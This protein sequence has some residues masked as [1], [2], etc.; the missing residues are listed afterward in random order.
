[1]SILLFPLGLLILEN[2]PLTYIYITKHM[3]NTLQTF[4]TDMQNYL[5]IINDLDGLLSQLTRLIGNFNTTILN[6][7]LNIMVETDNAL[8]I[9]APAA[10]DNTLAQQLSRRVIEL[11]RLIN[12]RTSDVQTLLDKGSVLET[13]IKIEQPQFTSKILSRADEFKKIKS[14]YKPF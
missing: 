9:D 14:T 13:Q 6:H 4:T 12:L 5:L 2:P 3:E 1:M 10:M 8:V 11:D 7:N